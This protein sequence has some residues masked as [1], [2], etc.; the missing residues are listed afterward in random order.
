MESNQ[1]KIVPSL[2]STNAILRGRKCNNFAVYDHYL[3][4]SLIITWYIT[5]ILQLLFKTDHYS[6]LEG[7]VYAHNFEINCGTDQAQLPF[8]VQC[9]I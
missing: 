2:T 1:V 7:Y 6:M 9:L 3:E 4:K 8:K 5:V